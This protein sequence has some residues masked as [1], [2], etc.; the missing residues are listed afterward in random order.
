MFYVSRVVE[1]SKKINQI[2][3]SVTPAINIIEQYRN[4]TAIASTEY[5]AYL[6]I[7]ELWPCTVYSPICN[8]LEIQGLGDKQLDEEAMIRLKKPFKK[9]S[10][11]IIVWAKA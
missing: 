11:G 7:A 9:H 10:K 2:F 5:C 4:H 1:M 8:T 3:T 6:N